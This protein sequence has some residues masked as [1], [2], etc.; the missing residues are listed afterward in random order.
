MLGLAASAADIVSVGIN[1][2]AG[3]LTA[4]SYADAAREAVDRKLGWVRQAADDR[5]DDIEICVR[6]LRTDITDD[7]EA[8]R[9][10]FAAELGLDSAQLRDSPHFLIG[11]AD[12]IADDLRRYRDELGVSYYV[13]SGDRADD[14]AAVVRQ[15]ADG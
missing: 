9:G 10:R 12:K 5:W 2:S 7:D 11:P 8:A 3:A 4:A 1:A 14:F 6:V 15:A 13:V